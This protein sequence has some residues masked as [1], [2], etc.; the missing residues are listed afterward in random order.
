[1]RL[2]A[3]AKWP[4]A[5]ATV[6]HVGVQPRGHARTPQTI[7]MKNR[8]ILLYVFPGLERIALLLARTIADKLPGTRFAAVIVREDYPTEPT[9]FLRAHAGELIRPILSQSEMTSPVL[10]GRVRYEPAVVRRL[11]REY[12]EPSFWHF[13]QADRYLSFTRYGTLYR[14]GSER[15]P[16]ELLAIVQNRF[17]SIERLFDE[18]DP[19]TVLFCDPDTSPGTAP[20]V[21]RVAHRRRV[22]MLVPH[23]TRVGHTTLLNDTIYSRFRHVEHRF[24][25]IRNGVESPSREEA[26]R[27]LQ[28][29][30]AGEGRYH[31]LL[32]DSSPSTRRDRFVERLRS[33]SV[34]AK[35]MLREIVTPRASRDPVH[36]PL[37]DRFTT[38]VVR[39]VRRWRTAGGTPFEEARA[40]EKY[41]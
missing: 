4:R 11:E 25:Q 2:P 18:F 33:A 24:E 20:I 37:W 22:P 23:R 19:T 28:E 38:S 7:R 32:A 39:Q 35:T 3:L 1:M 30:R 41:V 26:E 9:N 29:I 40:G 8:R 10:E 12:G 36:I 13:V 34:Q 15:P 5:T 27:R 21:D 17:L 16:E 31:P 14:Y 6:P